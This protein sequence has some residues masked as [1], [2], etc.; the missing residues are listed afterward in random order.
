[1]VKHSYPALILKHRSTKDIDQ[2][3]YH[4]NKHDR[5]DEVLTY[6]GKF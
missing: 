4:Q 5:V 1:M 2:R 3:K 6:G